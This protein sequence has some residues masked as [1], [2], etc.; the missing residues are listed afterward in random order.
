MCF[1]P[2]RPGVYH[3]GPGVELTGQEIIKHNLCEN[4]LVRVH[5]YMTGKTGS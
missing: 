1:S 3:K 5:K 4:M 2:V